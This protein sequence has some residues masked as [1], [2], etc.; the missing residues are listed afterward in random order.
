MFAPD[1]RPSRFLLVLWLVLAVLA[2]LALLATWSLLGPVPHETPTELASVSVGMQPVSLAWSADGGYLAAGTWGS[3]GENG[4]SEV[5]VVDVARGCITTTLKVTGWVEGLAFAPDGKWLAVASRQPTSPAAAPVELVVFDVP[6][7]TARFTA[8]AFAPSHRF[9]DL[10]WAGDGQTLC[11]LEAPQAGEPGKTQ[12]RR[13]AVPAFAEQRGITA[14]QLDRYEALAV[15]PDGDTLAVAD[16]CQGADG[17]TCVVRLFDLGKGTERASSRAVPAGAIPP[18]LGFTPDGKAVGVHA[19]DPGKLSWWDAAT[20]QPAKPAG[21]RFA[22]QPAG[23]SDLASRACITPD[24]AIQALGYERHR[25]LGDLGWDNR[26]H[27]FGAFVEVRASTSTRTRTWRVGVLPAAP[28]LAFSPDG[29][30]LAGTVMQPTGGSILIWAVPKSK[31]KPLMSIP[32]PISA[33]WVLPTPECDYHNSP[34]GA[35]FDK[36]DLGL[37]EEPFPELY[38]RGDFPRARL[39]G[40]TRVV[41]F[42]AVWY[43]CPFHF[44]RPA[45]EIEG[46]GADDYFHERLAGRIVSNCLGTARVYHH[47][48]EALADL[49]RCDLGVGHI[50]Q[51]ACSRGSE[52]SKVA[53]VVLKGDLKALPV[54]ADALEEEGHSLAEK[55]RELCPAPKKCMTRKKT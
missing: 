34:L 12:V 27:E 28:A 21:A 51:V 1:R 11:A 30:K 32:L 6:A 44:T 42:K 14:G 31:G 24:G 10:A 19:G 50:W 8:R 33:W 38:V 47:R 15:S 36:Y 37:N 26:Q 18:R 4:S 40:D 52:A 23:L 16:A 43:F 53:R 13:W 3:G 2:L 17:K 25:G 9:L 39:E 7:F 55:V 22:V 46:H 45:E 48:D 35:D 20:G 5:F 54:L 49:A 29:T 41:D